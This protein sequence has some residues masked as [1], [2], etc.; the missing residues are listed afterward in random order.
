MKMVTIK[1]VLAKQHILAK[2]SIKWPSK[3]ASLNGDIKEEVYMYQP[4]E[5]YVARKE[6]LVCR[7]F[8]ALNG[9]K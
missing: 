7:L 6:H 1:L 5:F 4:Q 3:C 8:K 9:L 2:K